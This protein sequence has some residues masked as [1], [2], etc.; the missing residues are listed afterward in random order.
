MNDTFPQRIPPSFARR[1][2]WADPR[3][4]LLRQVALSPEE[5]RE[6]AGYS[7]DPLDEAS[8][9]PVPGVLRKYRGRALLLVS[10]ACPI[11]CRYC[12]RRHDRGESAPRG[13]AEW[14]PAL[15]LLRGDGEL[16]EVIYSGGD[17]L[18]RDDAFLAALT[19]RVEAMPQV[20]RLRIHTR[21]A[22]AVPE[23]VTPTLTAWLGASRLQPVM[24]VHVNHPRELDGE[25]VAALGRLAGAGV[26]L[27]N[28]SVLL[29]GVNDDAAV[30][31][32]LSERLMAAQVTPYYL[33]QLDPVAG[34]AHFAVSDQR[35]L[36]LMRHWRRSAPGYLIPRLVREIPGAEGKVPLCDP[37]GE[38]S[39]DERRHFA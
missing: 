35:A 38:E 25:A 17:P 16:R 10:R 11:H 22:V 8:V 3:D 15:E 2:D 6:V 1:I 13:L 33:H 39:A 26:R 14:T 37:E 31:A 21:M 20:R 18:M 30:L 5:F 23:R 32:E 34:A 9:S 4:P 19:Q 12:F 27:F 7:S 29:A 28:Q 36:G 24:V